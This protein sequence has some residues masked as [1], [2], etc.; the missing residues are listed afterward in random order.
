MGAPFVAVCVPAYGAEAFLEPTLRSL[1]AQDRPAD[2]I[3]VSVDPAGD[4]TEE[5]ARDLLSGRRARI[6]VQ[7]QRLG[8]V[9]N[10][11]A[12]L[13]LAR[14][15]HAMILPHDDLLAPAYL[16]ACLDALAANPGAALAYSDIE[17]INNGNIVSETA[18]TGAVVTRAAAIME[19]HLPAIAWRAVFDRRRARRHLVPSFALGDF[20]AD[21]LWVARMAMQGEMVRVP[22][23][24]Y[25][26]RLKSPSA[27]SVWYRATPEE[28]DE[29]WV[30][31]CIE[32]A[33]AMLSLRPDLALVPK[34]R[35]AF[36]S[37]L[38]REH[39][40]FADV[41]GPPAVLGP[42]WRWRDLAQIYRRVAGRSRP[43]SWMTERK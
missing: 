38:A 27:H 31:H 3:V 8:W 42:D 37:R 20:A 12:A 32:M 18:E 10:T 11:N 43:Y 34:F 36:R 33:R 16:G 1:L 39:T 35:A 22:G 2:E 28:K 29:M 14:G 6:V 41:S 21:T 23:A 30:V 26:K 40:T 9:G 7:P 5:V 24:L 4:R 17:I 25:R 19:R 15:D 13:R